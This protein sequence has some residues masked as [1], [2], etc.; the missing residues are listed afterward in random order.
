MLIRCDHREVVAIGDARGLAGVPV[1]RV[2]VGAAAVDPHEHQ[3]SER[4]GGHRL[5]GQRE[6]FG[7]QAL[8][9]SQPVVPEALEDSGR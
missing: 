8:A 1:C 2:E 4:L 5:A 9:L 7:A 3:V 6:Q